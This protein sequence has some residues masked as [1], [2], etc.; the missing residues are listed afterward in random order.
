MFLKIKNNKNIK[1]YFFYPLIAL[2]IS[3]L[4]IKLESIVYYKINSLFIVK[5]YSLK[6]LNKKEIIDSYLN[7]IPS[8]Y[9]SKIKEE[10]K[11]FEYFFH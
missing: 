2:I 4:L 8:K 3:I 1:Y 7:T 10:R 11:S 6:N 5:L 9:D